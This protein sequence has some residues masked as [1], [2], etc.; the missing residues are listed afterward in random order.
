MC[1]QITITFESEE[2]ADEIRLICT[3]KGITLADYVVENFEWDDQPDC[4][5]GEPISE[6]IC[7]P[8]DW[9]DNCPDKV[10]D[11]GK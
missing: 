4:I 7:S 8:C 6:D 3:R 10:V 1:N 9:N 11:Y 2:Q 5:K